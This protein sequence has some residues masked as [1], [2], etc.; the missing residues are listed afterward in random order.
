MW[1]MWVADAADYDAISDT[2]QCLYDD[3]DDERCS[4]DRQAAGST[5]RRPTESESI[6]GRDGRKMNGE[7]RDKCTDKFADKLDRRV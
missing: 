7:G 4:A 2:S 1:Q 6:D 3:L 5:A